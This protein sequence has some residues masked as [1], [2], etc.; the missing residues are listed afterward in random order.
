M[1]KTIQFGYNKWFAILAMS[2][3]SILI[4]IFIVRI[5]QLNDPKQTKVLGYFIFFLSVLLFVAIYKYL[6]PFLNK[7]VAL[8]LNELYL[9]DNI[10]N[11]TVNW[12]NIVNLNL[13]RFRNGSGGIAIYLKDKQQ[14]ISNLNFFQ[15]LRSWISNFSYDTP[16]IIP[17][18]YISGN[19]D[20]I[21]QTINEYFRSKTI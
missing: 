5:Y 12:D 1:K 2:L 20:E 21:F 7:R 4:I 19:N 3:F 16:L 10:S 9:I 13:I 15:K 18:Q 17:L 6:I 11:R 14:F 8:E